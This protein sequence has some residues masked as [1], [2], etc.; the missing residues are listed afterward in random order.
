[1]A[2][3][4]RSFLL[5]RTKNYFKE[6]K[7]WKR[8]YVLCVNYNNN[9]KA[10][11][12]ISK[13]DTRRLIV[14]RYTKDHK[15]SQEENI[16][17]YNGNLKNQIRNLKIFSLGT[18]F[19][20][21]AIQPL[22]IT[23][24]SKVG[25][26]TGLIAAIMVAVF[27]ILSPIVLNLV[28]KRY[29]TNAYYNP[30]EQKYVATTYTLFLRVDKIE[31]TPDDVVVPDITGLFTTCFI[32]NKPLFFDE[33]LFVDYDHYAKIMGLDKPVDYKLNIT[34]SNDVS[35]K[36]DQSEEGNKKHTF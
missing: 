2:L 5:Q 21:L 17:I 14:N 29:V 9:I 35:I 16:V 32:K 26:T 34:D 7:N 30:Q 23:K 13:V 27:S 22:I 20:G 1:M 24:A 12:P 3:I 6:T 28:T 19:C 11:I 33:S 36:G 4:L 15:N 18:S 25:S 10:T 31:F 8:S